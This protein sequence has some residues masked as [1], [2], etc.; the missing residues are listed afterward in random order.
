[1]RQSRFPDT[2][3]AFG[4]VV[5]FKDNFFDAG[6]LPETGFNELKFNAGFI[7]GFVGA[8]ERQLT[9]QGYDSGLNRELYFAK[10]YSPTSQ[11]T[12][13]GSADPKVS[14][15]PQFWPPVLKSVE[16]RVSSGKSRICAI[17]FINRHS[18]E[19]SLIL[20]SSD[21]LIGKIIAQMSR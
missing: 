6:N 19:F 1:M 18:G 10:I 14:R 17:Q 7:S 21:L 20:S 8:D 13:D 5:Y 11:L 4:P 16:D 3:F 15:L 12:S 2:A 9:L